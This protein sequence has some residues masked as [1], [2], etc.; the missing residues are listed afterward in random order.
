MTA[1]PS[2]FLK[3]NIIFWLCWIFVDVRWLSLIA[4]SRGFLS[5]CGAGAALVVKHGLQ[6]SGSA[7]G[8]LGLSCSALSGIL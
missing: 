6:S 8:V 3:I 7:V 5:S 4:A 2:Y 1:I